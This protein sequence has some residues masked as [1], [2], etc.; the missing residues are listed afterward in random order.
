MKL[1]DFLR[2]AIRTFIDAFVGVLAIALVPALNDLVQNAVSGDGS[3]I[4]LDLNLYRNI[5]LAACVAGV[6][7][8]I[9]LVKNWAEDN[10]SFPSVLK[11]NPSAGQN[12]V[13]V[14]PP[15]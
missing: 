8:L 6:I 10:T 3:T 7:S 1:P 12:P 4:E 5:L 13:T 11:A 9:T 2:R 14:D 15:K